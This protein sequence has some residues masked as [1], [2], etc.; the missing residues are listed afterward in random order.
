MKPAFRLPFAVAALTAVAVACGGSTFEPSGDGGGGGSSSGGGDAG[1][2]SDTGVADTGVPDT[3]VVETGTGHDAGT[4]ECPAS[5]PGSGATCS[6]A[7]LTCEW[8]ASNVPDCDTEATCTNGEWA[9]TAPNPGGLDCGGGPKITCPPSFASVPV[10]DACSPDG[11][12]CDYPEGRCGCA[13]GGGPIRLIDGSVQAFW[14][15]QNPAAGCPKP[16][17]LLGSSCA[18]E[19]LECDYGTCGTIP[20]GNAEQCTGGV[21]V[22]AEVGCPL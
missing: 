7:G 8:G 1:G 4:I 3:G 20:G 14:S 18:M 21:W 11:G 19:G 10:G 17:P 13:A 6:R 16:R 15:C 12:Y 2:S 5:V 9:V 22:T